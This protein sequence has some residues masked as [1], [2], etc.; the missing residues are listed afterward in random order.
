[1]GGLAFVCVGGGVAKPPHPTAP[2]S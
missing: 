1:M 2:V